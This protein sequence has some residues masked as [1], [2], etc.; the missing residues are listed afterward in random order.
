[1]TSSYSCRNLYFGYNA[2]NGCCFYNFNQ[3][4]STIR[5]TYYDNP[6]LR[7]GTYTSY[8]ENNSCYRFRNCMTSAYSCINIY[9]GFYGITG[10]CYYN[11]DPTTS[12]TPAIRTVQNHNCCPHDFPGYIRSVCYK[13]RDCTMSERMFFVHDGVF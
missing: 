6:L 4:T 13:R 5:T 3:T 1:M 7:C 9:F 12:T 10:C 11:L 8:F 2:K